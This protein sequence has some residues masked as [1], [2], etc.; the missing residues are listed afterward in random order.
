MFFNINKIDLSNQLVIY[1][2]FL[3]KKDCEYL[4]ELYENTNIK[5]EALKNLE[6]DNSFKNVSIY[7]DN[8]RNKNIFKDIKYL[9]D[10]FNK[11]FDFDIKKEL[12]DSVVIKYNEGNHAPWH[13]DLGSYDASVLRKIN[14]IILLND[15]DSFIGGDFE[16]FYSG[17]Q[18]IDMKQG[19]LVLLLPFLQH[20]VTQIEKGI[21]YS[22]VTQAIGNRSF[23]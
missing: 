17:I 13:Q 22:F 1:R 5:N 18:K 8:K 14:A 6:K 9:V 4:I 21:R 20:R 2:N 7:S 3:E 10:K 23:K 11:N 16:I 12:S 15:R 19:D